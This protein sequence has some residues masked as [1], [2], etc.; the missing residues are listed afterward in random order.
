MGQ[1]ESRIDP[2]VEPVTLSDRSL[3]AVAN[4]IK[5]GKATNIVVMTGA[6]ISTSAG[7]PDFRSPKTGLY[8]NLARL[9]LPYPEAVFTLDFFRENPVP[10]Y[11]LAKE[12]YPGNFYPT[13][14]H[15]F[16]ALLHEKGLL[17]ML[18]T[19]NIDCL[20]RRAGVPDS[21]VIEAHGSFATQGC[22]DCKREYPDELMKPAVL[23]GAVP[24]C[25]EP[26]CNGLV[27]P[28]IVFFGEGLPSKFFNNTRRVDEADLVFVMGTS[29]SVAPFSRLPTYAGEGVPRVLFNMEA[30]GD[31]GSRADDVLELGGC[32]DGVKK[33]AELLGWTEELEAL[34]VEAGP[35]ER[36]SEALR[37]KEAKKIMTKDQLLEEHEKKVKDQLEKEKSSVPTP[38]VKIERIVEG[39]AATESAKEN[40]LPMAPVLDTT[41]PQ[42]RPNKAESKI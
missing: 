36:K 6:G 9:N 23:A 31:M 25:V 35:E 7:I 29:L 32:D 18:F 21:L 41:L 2:S 10:F 3:E 12:L 33:L 17:K 40:S 5:A 4:L 8:D 1:E 16:I 38:E 26:R 19:Q 22:I 37:E 27:K 11:V 34:W 30:V 20:E 14:A 28:D 13:I 42:N 39:I 24:H 15:S